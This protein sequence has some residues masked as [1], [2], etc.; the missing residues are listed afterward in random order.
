[1]AKQVFRDGTEVVRFYARAVKSGPFVFVSGY[2]S[3]KTMLQNP[4]FKNRRLVS[5]PVEPSSLR[6]AISDVFGSI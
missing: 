4:R 5:K 3:P 2:N 6:Q 1:M